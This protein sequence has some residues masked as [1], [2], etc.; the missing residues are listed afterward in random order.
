MV[1]SGRAT[2]SQWSQPDPLHLVLC[3]PLLG[4]V[5]K[6]SRARAFVAA[7]SCACFECAAVGEVSGDPG[8][9]KRW[10]PIG[11]VMPVVAAPSGRFGAHM[12]EEMSVLGFSVDP[13]LRALR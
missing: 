8:C 2:S 1:F 4:A 10:H 11:A 12:I 3:E 7:I 13:S 9:A 5:I 6:L